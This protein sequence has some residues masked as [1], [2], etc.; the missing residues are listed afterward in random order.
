MYSKN[1]INSERPQVISETPKD[2]VNSE[3]PED[4]VKSE[5]STDKHD[6]DT[7]AESESKKAEEPLAGQERVE[8]KSP[9]SVTY[10]SILVNSLSAEEVGGGR[11]ELVTENGK[12][13]KV[14]PASL[15]V[16]AAF[17]SEHRRT[18][19]ISWKD[20]P[21]TSASSLKVSALA[22]SEASAVFEGCL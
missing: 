14:T 17:P 4:I 6:V 5:N 1:E 12:T 10:K 21:C 20:E 3:N 18:R 11:G 9:D 15:S 8:V 22:R 7:A 2:E 13:F 16:N 19:R